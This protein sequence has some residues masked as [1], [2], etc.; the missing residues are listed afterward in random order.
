M[1]WELRRLTP[2][3]GHSALASRDRPQYSAKRS[4]PSGIQEVRYGRMEAVYVAT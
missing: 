1:A 4:E 2:T 3:K